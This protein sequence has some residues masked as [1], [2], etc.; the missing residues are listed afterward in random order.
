MK[1]ANT[2]IKNSELELATL[3]DTLEGMY[4]KWF[5]LYILFA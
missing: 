3:L 5:S 2:A 1:K 4:E